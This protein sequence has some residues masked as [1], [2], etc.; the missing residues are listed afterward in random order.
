MKRRT[1]LKPQDIL[2]TR[3]KKGRMFLGPP[4]AGCFGG[5]MPC[6]LHS[7]RSGLYLVGLEMF[8]TELAPR[9]WYWEGKRIYFMDETA[10]KRRDRRRAVWVFKTAKPAKKR[11]LAMCEEVEEYNRRAREKAREAMKKL[12][13]DDPSVRIEGALALNDL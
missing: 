5:M 6:I 9:L 4:Y 10:R 7:R 1:D 12:E 3:I 13:S 11:F 2:K 8:V